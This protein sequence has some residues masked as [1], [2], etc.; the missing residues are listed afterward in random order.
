LPTAV[1]VFKTG[2]DGH[3]ML[4]GSKTTNWHEIDQAGSVT[5]LTDDSDDPPQSNVGY[6]L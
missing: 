3:V 2:G 4:T 1:K 6:F 5:D